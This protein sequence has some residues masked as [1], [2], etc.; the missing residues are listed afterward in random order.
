MIHWKRSLVVL[1]V[2]A[3]I[4]ASLAGFLGDGV[5]PFAIHWH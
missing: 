3:A 5:V 1:L 4:L 2:I